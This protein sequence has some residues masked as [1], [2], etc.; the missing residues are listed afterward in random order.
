MWLND[1]SCVRLRPQGRNDVWA[2]DFVQV[3]TREGRAV[4]LLIVIDKYTRECLAIRVGSSIRSTDVIDTQADL[5]TSGGCARPH[6]LGQR[7]GIHRQGG[8]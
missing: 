4:R 1:G 6:P 8:A 2:Y 3:S 5:M 7:D